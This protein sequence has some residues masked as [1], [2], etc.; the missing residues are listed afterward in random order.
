[1]SARRIVEEMEDIKRRGITNILFRDATFTLGMERTSE[2]CDLLIKKKL[3]MV[4]WC[5]T[6][7]NVLS[8]DLLKLMKRA[9]CLGINVGVE[10]L[11]AELILSEGKPGVTL[12]DVIRLRKEAKKIGMKLHFLMIVGLPNDNLDG[13]Y[14][15]LKYLLKPHSQLL[16][17]L[18][19]NFLFY[20]QPHR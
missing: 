14:G 6:R 2:M 19:R 3:N 7:I 15:S 11:N 20:M 12:P 10:T 16:N 8:P 13:L 18:F 9:G 17:C 1:M 5:E 4:W